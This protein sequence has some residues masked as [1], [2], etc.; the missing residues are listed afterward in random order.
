MAYETSLLVLMIVCLTIALFGC[1]KNKFTIN[2]VNYDGTVLEIDENVKK[3]DVHSFDGETPIRE[4]SID[5]VYTFSGW[6]EGKKDGNVITYTAEFSGE[7]RNYSVKFVNDNESEILRY[8]APY[9]STATFN[10]ENPTSQ[11]NTKEGYL[12]VGWDRALDVV[13]G[14][15]TYKATYSQFYTIT[16]ADDG[17]NTI[18]TMMVEEGDVPEY[19]GPAPTKDSTL[20][21]QY[22]FSNWS[23]SIVAASSA[24]TYTATFDESFINY[25]IRF[26]NEDGT[27]LQETK[28]HYGT[29]VS[30]PS[31]P[32][33][34]EDVANTYE[35]IG[36]NKEITDV[37]ASV[38]YK[39]TYNIIAKIFQIKFVNTNGTVLQTENLKYGDDVIYNQEVL[40]YSDDFTTFTQDG[41]TPQLVNKCEKSVTYVAKYKATYTNPNAFVFEYFDDSNL[42]YKVVGLSSSA[43]SNITH[44]VI[45]SAYNDKPVVSIGDEAFNTCSK[46]EYLFI[47]SSVV[48]IGKKGIYR[49]YQLTEIEFG[50]NSLLEEIKE[51]GI[52]YNSKLVNFDIPASLKIIERLGLCDNESWEVDELRLP[53]IA[54][55]YGWFIASTK[56][57]KVVFGKSL[58]YVSN[59]AFMSNQMRSYLTSV[60]VEEGGKYFFSLNDFLYRNNYNADGEL[61]D[62]YLMS[63]PRGYAAK[64]EN[65]AIYEGTTVW[66]SYGIYG[67]SYIKSIVFPSTLREIKANGLY[68][69]PAIRQ[70]SFG[71][72][73]EV[74]GSGAFKSLSLLTK[75][76]FGSGL[77]EFD[78]SAFENCLELAEINISDDNPYFVAEN[79]IVFNKDK[80]KLVKYCEAKTNPS[81]TIPSTVQTI[82]IRAFYNNRNI[83]DVKIPV[84]VT[85]I[86]E[87]AFYFATELT[88]IDYAGTKDQWLQIYKH[89][90]NENNHYYSSTKLTKIVCTDEEITL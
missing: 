39:A 70:L 25:V 80:T 77:K 45:P 68:E 19:N 55:I 4:S 64:T 12:F 90:E 84:S 67:N 63:I 62:V 52:S 26:E 82:G 83:T 74:V 56:V 29:S 48:T 75:I 78:G 17:G 8:D 71:D 66:N 7:V 47:P 31:D 50:E 37:T 81:Y 72:S 3:K 51:N 59:D 86:E 61:I 20:V 40:S 6:S 2:W 88:T 46:L 18:H 28:Q 32:E 42:Q 10:G 23:P 54:H 60:E 38:T 35:F 24:A 21:Y 27:L 16:F 89:Y 53:N 69:A 41:W 44:V 9:G 43:K 34:V 22:S 33:K 15:V 57:R 49:N 76:S 1:G 65:V 58:I 87:K 11:I 13:R 73:L 14:D 79:N 5:T 30:A 85:K 36:W